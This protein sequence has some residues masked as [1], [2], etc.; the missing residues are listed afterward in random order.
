MKTRIKADPR[1]MFFRDAPY[2][3]P[4][5][6][7]A[8]RKRRGIDAVAI[9]YSN[10]TRQKL[11]T[12][13]RDALGLVTLSQETGNTLVK[14]D[15]ILSRGNYGSLVTG[16]IAQV[17]STTMR[18][19][20]VAG[21]YLV[22]KRSFGDLTP[23]PLLEVTLKGYPLPVY[24]HPGTMG[25][26]RNVWRDAL[27]PVSIHERVLEQAANDIGKS[28]GL[29]NQEI[30]GPPADRIVYVDYGHAITA[31]SAQ[32]SQWPAVAGIWDGPCWGMWHNEREVALRWLY[33]LVTRTSHEA[34]IYSILPANKPQV[35]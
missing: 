21:R 32:G 24:V 34:A 17:T 28:P 15:A 9:C 10:A 27:Q 35:Y 16:E 19:F 25:Q 31:H 22:K 23:F 7:I 2:I 26:P 20:T 3:Q 12:M 29:L 5:Q 11:N 8:D 4:A 30:G 13:I 18:L 6:W 33:T 14:G 1:L